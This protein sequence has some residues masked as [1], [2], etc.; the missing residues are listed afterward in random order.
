MK[1]IMDRFDFFEL[2]KSQF[3]LCKRENLNFENNFSLEAFLRENEERIKNMDINSQENDALG[4]MYQQRLKK[5]SKKKFGQF[6]T[7]KAV[8][9]TILNCIDY[10]KNAPILDKKIIDLSCGSGSF[11]IEAV[12]RFIQRFLLVKNITAVSD[13]S[14]KEGK[15]LLCLINNNIYGIDLNPIACGLCQL[16]IHLRLKELYQKISKYEKDFLPPRFSIFNL[17]SLNI[18]KLK[19]FNIYFRAFDYVIGNPPYIFIRDISRE[20]KELIED[21]FETNK[22]QYD[23]YQIFIELGI[24]LLKEHGYLGY[25]LPD[26]L[27]ALSNRRIIRKYIFDTSKIKNIY[28]CGQKF[29]DAT[30]SNIILTIQK[31]KNPEARNGNKIRIKHLNSQNRQRFLSQKYIKSWNYKFL[32]NLTDMDRKVLDYLN[33][34]NPNL[35]EIMKKKNYKISL[36]RG[37]ELG[38]E[39]EIIYCKNCETFLP[40]PKKASYCNNCQNQL[41]RSLIEKIIINDPPKNE[42]VNYAKYI[43]SMGRYRINEYKFII[44]DKRGINYKNLA[45]YKNT[46]LIRQLNHGN[47]VCATYHN[48]LAYNSQ[49]IYNLKIV[50]TPIPEFNHPYLLGL[51]NSHL[52][53]YYFMKSFG[54]YKE[55]FPRILIGK[56][57][58]IP[59]KI[60]KTKKEK[61]LASIVSKKVKTLLNSTNKSESELLQEKI[62]ESVFE[63][64]RIPQTQRKYIL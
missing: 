23:I 40:L 18:A 26:S 46:I 64:Y 1:K 57:K 38:K 63:L 37:V 16:N 62:D 34:M 50:K 48:D 10:Q 25:I 60:P 24:K 15:E 20:H 51:I 17:N 44:L 59:I 21:H 33:S 45:R 54:S 11:L 52:I 9:K 58:K 2:I 4:K 8:V 53:S 27:L 14:P 22:G 35:R 32:I 55:L 12:N 19:D 28:V 56:I 13:L 29:N 7:S 31:E 41:D 47:M 30:V 42:K 43:F 36:G 49:S 3:E 61:K 6:Y 5:T 39:G